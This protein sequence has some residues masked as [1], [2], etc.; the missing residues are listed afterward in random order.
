V[1]YSLESFIVFFN[2]NSKKHADFE[3]KEKMDENSQVNQGEICGECGK[4]YASL[5]C[6]N[7]DVMFCEKCSDR[8]HSKAL[9][10]HSRVQARNR[11]DR[12]SEFCE[13]HKDEKFKYFCLECSK[14]LCMDC[15]DGDHAKHDVM[16]LVQAVDDLDQNIR[17]E[18]SSKFEL[19]SQNVSMITVI[20][21][22]ANDTFQEFANE[23]EK[24]KNTAERVEKVSN[25][26]K[27]KF[28]KFREGFQEKFGYLEGLK[29]TPSAYFTAANQLRLCL[30]ENFNRILLVKNET[31]QLLNYLN[32]PMPN[33]GS[34]SLYM[35]KLEFPEIRYRHSDFKDSCILKSWSGI[36]QIKEWF[37]KPVDFHLLYRGSRD[38]FKASEFHRLCD[39]QGATFT[40]LKSANGYIFGGF[41]SRSWTSSSLYHSCDGDAWLFSLTNPKNLPLK[42]PSNNTGACMYD[43]ISYGPTYGG[44]HDLHIADMANSNSL[45]YC[46]LGGSYLSPQIQ[47]G[48]TFLCGSFNFQ[49]SEIEVYQVR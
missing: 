33:N 38:G 8:I 13:E 42:I 41:V 24:R 9:S 1:N 25:S 7:C 20:G 48:L 44:N 18:I 2:S 27:Q 47:D 4:K 21:K 34:L 31:Q 23:V 46:K 10:K 28:G 45:S 12:I 36:K 3:E 26:E 15:K 5:Y 11:P 17:E 14:Q 32:A 40:V 35:G 37:G 29:C 16:S 49:I 19:Y 39:N 30:V 43:N 22:M 6:S